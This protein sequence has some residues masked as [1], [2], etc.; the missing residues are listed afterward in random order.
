MDYIKRNLI[1]LL[2]VIWS[3]AFWFC[4]TRNVSKTQHWSSL[5]CPPSL[6][7]TPDETSEETDGI[8]VKGF[9]SISPALHKLPDFFI[10]WSFSASS[11]VISPLSSR[12]TDLFAWARKVV[13]VIK[14]TATAGIY[15]FY[16][17]MLPR[18]FSAMRP[19][20]ANRSHKSTIS[21][22]LL[23]KIGLLVYQLHNH[24][25]IFKSG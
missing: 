5:K 10:L 2:L 23:N 17:F 7:P 4:T 22:S 15:S 11:Y 14:C 16:Y 12:V 19:G 9:T 6:R 21:N 24:S 1:I 13:S 25:R 20:D 3:P 8:R 18:F